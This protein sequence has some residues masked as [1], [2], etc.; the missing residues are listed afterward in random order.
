MRPAEV[1]IS[2]RQNSERQLDGWMN[3][4]EVRMKVKKEEGR[5]INEKI[6]S[7]R[8]KEGG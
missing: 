2:G 7:Y 1:R 8:M 4:V 3:V 6:N 5:S